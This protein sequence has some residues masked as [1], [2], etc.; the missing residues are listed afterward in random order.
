MKQIVKGWDFIRILRLM[1]GIA[2]GGYALWTGD[3]LL[4]FL[5]GMLIVQA[6]LNWSCCSAS[7]CG[8]AS[9]GKAVYKDFVKPYDKNM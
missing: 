3:Y 2:F 5:S 9:D 1:L 6:V 4:L 8:T 7:G